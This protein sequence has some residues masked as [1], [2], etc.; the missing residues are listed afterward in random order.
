MTKWHNAS[1]QFVFS[2]VV[3]LFAP[4]KSLLLSLPFMMTKFV[5]FFLMLTWVNARAQEAS[6]ISG[7]ITDAGGHPIAGVSIH[8][9]NTNLAT[10]TREDGTFVLSNLRTGNYTLEITALGFASA[11]KDVVIGTTNPDAITVSLSETSIQLDA[12]VVTAQKKEEEL[13]TIPSSISALSS[14]QVQ[15]YRLWNSKD[16]TAIVPNLYSADPGDGRNVTSLRGI[17][18][19]SYDPAVATYMDGVNQFGLDTYIAQLFDIERIEVLRGPQGTLYGRNAMGGVINIITQQPTNIT[20]GFMEAS[21]GNYGQQ[22]YGFG[23]RTPMI[24]DKLFFGLAGVYDQTNGFYTNQFDN[25]HFDKKHSITGNYYLKYIA[26]TRWVVT[27]NLKHN[28]NR[29]H[30]A[31]PLAGTLADALAQPFKVNQNAPAK[32][33][34]NIFN[35]SLTANYAGSRMNFSSQTSYQSNYR[36]YENPLDGDFSPIDGVTIINNYG[37]KWN[38]VEVLTQ[39]FRLSS[40]A[41]T[42]LPLQWT[43]GT[44]LYSQHNPVKLATRFGKDAAFLG[45]GDSLFSVINTTTG[46]NIGAA[47]FGQASYAIGKLDL[48]AGLR[49]D[50]EHKRQQVLGEY[51]HDPDPKPIFAIR[52]DTFAT[53]SYGA[54]SPKLTVAYRLSV[55]NIVFGTYSRGFRTGGLTQ[56]SS[57]PS[58]P[59]LYAYKPEYSNNVEVGTKNAFFDNRFKIN[60]AAFY[61]DIID[62]QVPTLILP[63]TI[64]V[65]KN[66]GKLTS[67]GL[68]VELAA[69]LLKGLQLFYNA[70]VNDATYKTLKLAQNGQEINLEGK[71]QIYTPSM[72][73]MLAAQ[74]EYSLGDAQKMRVVFRGEWVY[75]GDHYFDLGNTIRQPGYSLLNT[76]FGFA[77]RNVDIMFWGRNMTN[78][79]YISYAYDFGGTHLGN[80]K[81]Y[82]VTVRV[83]F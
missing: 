25:S 75:L 19:T 21:A 13:Q 39:E 80:P 12:I 68:E 45:V 15:Q 71:H 30:G 40:P 50:Y 23:V 10:A 70:G 17:T 46:K 1:T 9:L 65:T 77:F 53:V 34:D 73:S 47:L 43:L 41:S 33:I 37:N 29:N 44:Y 36:Y 42:S 27:L 35:S 54:I 18:S 63:S 7:K 55:N 51:Q 62:A 57:D 66:T 16:L 38:K 56:L 6:S 4:V 26:G 78:K 8:M 48:T 61:M 2:P 64:T 72:T 3:C 82:G 52:P 58:Q 79:K 81:N 28:N 49:Y 74:Y 76:R 24:K 11:R 20:K 69:M 67:K 14:R 5:I 59:P 60:V 83:N 32:M 31:F 22:R